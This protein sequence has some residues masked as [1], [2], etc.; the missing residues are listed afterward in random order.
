MRLAFLG[1]PDFSVTALNALIEAGHD[2]V[3]VYSQPPRPAG[4]GKAL[5]PTPVHAAAEAAG[6]EVRTP[7][8]LRHGEAQ[9]A[10]ADLALDAAV[11]VAYGL[12]LPKTI[13]D[14]PAHGCF[15]I[16]AS[17][18]PRWRGAA[19]IQRAIEA[20]D[21]ESGVTIMQMDEGL[22]TGPMLLRESVPIGATTTAGQLHDALAIMGARMI[23]ETLRAAEDGEL[24]PVVQPDEGVTYAE[25]IRKEE[26]IID[27][28][29]TAEDIRRQIYAFN[30]FPGAFFTF[31]GER[32][33][34][35]EAEV[36]SGNGS[37]GQITDDVLTIACGH[38]LIRPSVVQRQGK[39]P[40]A[41]ADLLRGFDI[42]RGSQLDLPAEG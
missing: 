15:N 35:H 29:R 10:F 12:I 39:K 28:R 6:I 41:V 18:L 7:V 34:I 22:D 24:D 32:F 17:L 27:W 23:T 26:A 40:M 19:P 16:H 33:R 36:V 8:S 4:R 20:G 5:R 3:C 9:Q 25:K 38:D 14:A 30:P 21:S 31:G 13:L 1:T 2:I 42:P 37:P 11:V